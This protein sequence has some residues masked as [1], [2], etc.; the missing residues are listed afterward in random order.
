MR[1]E[2]LLKTFQETGALRRGHF[3]LSSGL[4][5]GIYFQS[6]LVLQHPDRADLLGRSLARDLAGYGP[7]VIVGPALGG[8]IIGWEVA[9]RLDVRGIFTEREGGTMCLRRGFAIEP[10]EKAV[11]VEDVV[12]TGKSTRET[13]DVIAAAGGKVVAVGA[14]VDRSGGRAGFDV[15]FHALLRLPVEAYEP[16]ECPLCR[17]GEPIDKPGSRPSPDAARARG[18]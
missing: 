6:A 13:M 3:Q 17:E 1:E 15:P 12:T 7:D 2:A 14:L 9:R 18:A 10:G 16:A 4:H 8:L 11:V 5:S